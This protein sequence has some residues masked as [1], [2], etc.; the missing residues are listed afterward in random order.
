MPIIEILRQINAIICIL[1]YMHYHSITKIIILKKN[2]IL[3]SIQYLKDKFIYYSSFKG[4]FVKDTGEIIACYGQDNL[5]RSRRNV[6]V[7]TKQ[8]IDTANYGLCVRNE[9]ILT[10]LL[11]NTKQYLIQIKTVQSYC[12]VINLKFIFFLFN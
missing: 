3:Y 8:S 4:I 10:T 1:K 12:K 11:T 2:L 9:T 6:V 7:M 5:L